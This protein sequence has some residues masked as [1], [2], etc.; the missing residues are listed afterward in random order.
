MTIILKYFLDGSLV[1]SKVH[2]Q[3][4]TLAIHFNLVLYSSIIKP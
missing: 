3:L 1:T 2:K 4:A